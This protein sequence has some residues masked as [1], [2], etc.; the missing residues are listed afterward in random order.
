MK[1]PTLR[2]GNPNELRY[3]AQFT[4]KKDLARRLRR[5]VRTIENWLSEREKLP[6]WVPELLRLQHMEQAERMRQ[7]GFAARR[8]RLGV[9]NEN[10]IEFIPQNKKAQSE[11]QAQASTPGD[12]FISSCA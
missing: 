11:D 2:Y 4:P 9:V 8:L 10:V 6:W 12:N 5:S 3:Y 7:M 1:Y